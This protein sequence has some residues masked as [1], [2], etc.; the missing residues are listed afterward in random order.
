MLALTRKLF[1]V[2]KSI[3]K[4]EWDWKNFHP[5]TRIKGKTVG[6]IGL[7]RVGRQVAKRIKGFDVNLLAYDP[8]IPADIFKTYNA[9]RVDYNTLLLQSDIVTF[10]VPLN[11]ETRYM[12]ST[13]Q[14]KK[15]KKKAILINAARGGIVDE[16]AL[17]NA[18]KK[19][20]IAGAGLDVLE[21]EPI[22]KD[23]PLLRI[24]NVII[25]PHMGWYSEDT[26]D[27]VQ[28]IAAEQILQCLQGKVPTNLV[29]K[30]VLKK[31]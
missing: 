23:N 22:Q 12:I 24:D 21:Q 8:Y 6:I 18:L 26:V 29:N 17:F 4:L 10:H 25:T 14:L 31:L 28:R 3:K 2:D 30:D 5:I 20:E 7:G 19:K 27:E 15:M 1:F 11:D 16:K 9:K 13:N